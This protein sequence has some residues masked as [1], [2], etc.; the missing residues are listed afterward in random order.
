LQDYLF[1]AKLR[2]LQ[3]QLLAN[4]YNPYKYSHQSSHWIKLVQ[5]ESTITDAD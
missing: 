4:S 5:T 2:Y 3:I 1:T